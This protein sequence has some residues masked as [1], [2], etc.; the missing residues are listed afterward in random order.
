MPFDKPFQTPLIMMIDGARLVIRSVRESAWI[1]AENWPN[2]SCNLLQQALAACAAA[3]E[4]RL[5]AHEARRAIVNAARG[6]GVAVQG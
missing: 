3:M 4:G 1:L 5:S 6:T 2:P